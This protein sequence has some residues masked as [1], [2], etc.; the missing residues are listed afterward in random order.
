MRRSPVDTPEDVAQVLAQAFLAHVLHQSTLPEFCR[1]DWADIPVGDKFMRM[2]EAARA[3]GFA[4][5]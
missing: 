4:V 5:A 3:L 1:Y 2:R